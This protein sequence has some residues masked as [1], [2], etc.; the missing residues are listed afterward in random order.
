MWGGNLEDIQAVA[1][2]GSIPIQ[3]S[4]AAAAVC[5]IQHDAHVSRG[6]WSRGRHGHNSGFLSTDT[7]PGC[8]CLLISLPQAW[9]SPHGSDTDDLRPSNCSTDGPGSS[10]A[11]TVSGHM[12]QKRG[13]QPAVCCIRDPRPG[14]DWRH[15]LFQSLLLTSYRPPVSHQPPSGHWWHRP[16]QSLLLTSP[17][18]PVSLQPRS[19]QWS[20][21]VSATINPHDAL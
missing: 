13:C 4:V 15:R 21:P 1:L 19:T 6:P 20:R 11:L 5:P 16:F 3:V 8:I 10:G 18:A 9:P 7:D 2:E 12:D 14:G 17:R